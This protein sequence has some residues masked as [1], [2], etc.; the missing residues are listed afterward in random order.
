MHPHCAQHGR[1]C[2]NGHRHS[3]Q[4][5]R[6]QNNTSK[7]SP[8]V[9]QLRAAVISAPRIS[10]KS[11]LFAYSFF[12]F[13]LAESPLRSWISGDILWLICRL[14]CWVLEALV[15]SFG[16]VICGVAYTLPA[17]AT[18]GLNQQHIRAHLTTKAPGPH[19]SSKPSMEQDEP[20][21]SGGSSKPSLP[22]S[23][24]CSQVPILYTAVYSC[25]C[26]IDVCCV[27]AMLFLLHMQSQLHK[28]GLYF[29]SHLKSIERVI[30]NKHILCVAKLTK[31]K[32][33]RNGSIFKNFSAKYSHLCVWEK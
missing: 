24:P 5:N 23:V 2:W 10:W 25:S 4:L 11:Y 1:S 3:Q 29:P 15:D 12:L 17:S 30:R 18:D 7:K 16:A 31:D 33:H 20:S 19:Y 8:A 21:L 6:R 27:C 14:I 22:S 9:S 28:C 32:Y 13:F 26:Y